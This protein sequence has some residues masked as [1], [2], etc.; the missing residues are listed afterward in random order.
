MKTTIKN[1]LCTLSLLTLA[2]ITGA[3][4][5]ATKFFSV[6]NHRFGAEGNYEFADRATGDLYQAHFAAWADGYVLD[7]KFRLASGEANLDVKRPSA[8]RDQKRRRSD[9]GFLRV[10]G[11]GSRSLPQRVGSDRASGRGDWVSVGISAVGNAY[12]RLLELLDLPEREG[13]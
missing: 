7:K 3:R 12:K 5:D 9:A 6:G 2:S 10:C 4:A 1:T 13:W 8:C 11:A